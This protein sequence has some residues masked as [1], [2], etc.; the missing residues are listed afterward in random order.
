MFQGI[1]DRS[2]YSSGRDFGRQRKRFLRCLLK[3]PVSA[4]SESAFRDLGDNHGGRLLIPLQIDRRQ[5]H[6]GVLAHAERGAKQS[7]RSLKF[8]S[9]G[10]H[11][12][13]GGDTGATPENIALVEIPFEAVGN[14]AGSFRRIALIMSG[15]SGEVARRRG[16]PLVAGPRVQIERFIEKA[17]G[18]DKVAAQTCQYAQREVAKS[19]AI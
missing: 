19:Y 1:V 13:Q 10:S 5:D 4:R 7:G 8:V 12:R 14:Q 16:A 18:G 11:Y 2:G 17:A 6:S 15:L 3:G 9:L